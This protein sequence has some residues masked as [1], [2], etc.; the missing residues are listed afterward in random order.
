MKILPS[1]TAG[2]AIIILIL[3]GFTVSA[4]EILA[5]QLAIS[6]LTR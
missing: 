1:I 3:A 5:V 4:A 2:Q 6:N